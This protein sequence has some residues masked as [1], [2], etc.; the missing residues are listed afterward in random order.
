MKDYSYQYYAGSMVYNY[1]KSLKYILFEEG[2][3]NK[4][5][6]AYTYEY[7]LKDHLGNTRVA[8]QPNG[9][10]TTTTQVAEY[11]PFGSSYL[12]QNPAGSN[13]YLY[14]GKEK[15]DDVLSGIAL[16]E[17]DYGARF[18]DPQIGRWHVIDPLTEKDRRWSP[19][20]FIFNNTIRFVD[21]EGMWGK[22]VHHLLLD[23][24]F[25]PKTDFSQKITIAQLNQLKLGSDNADSPFKGGSFPG[26]QSD[27]KEYIHGMRPEGMTLKEAKDAAD[28]WINDNVEAYVQT[29]DF[30]KLGEALHTLMDETCPAHRDQDGSPLKY[31]GFISRHGDLEN[32]DKIDKHDGKDG[33]ITK[34]EREKR[35]NEAIKNMRK[36][37][38]SS[39]KK[40]KEK[41][42]EEQKESHQ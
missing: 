8:F 22:E 9:G 2:L 41:E 24:A 35:Y 28:N 13:K 32:P 40:R 15:Q 11:Y 21:S 33:Y 26:N 10:G 27:S 38:D 37:V 30:E 14:N 31:V 39:L 20:S 12:P 19:Y 5:S 23:N 34:K 29:G 6:G 25:G 4:S 16:D 1:D 7:H 18:Y 17:Y 3:V 36:L 42:D